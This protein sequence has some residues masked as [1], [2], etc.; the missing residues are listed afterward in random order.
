[1]LESHRQ[2]LEGSVSDS[3]RKTKTHQK[4]IAEALDNY[5]KRVEHTDN[6]AIADWAF[7]K[8]YDVVKFSN[9]V[10]PVTKGYIKPSTVFAV[11]AK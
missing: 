6:N 11:K 2:A 1:M 9:M 5:R 7:G 8:G 4:W 10:D 3:W